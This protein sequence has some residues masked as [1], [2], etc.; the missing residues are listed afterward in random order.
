[1]ASLPCRG[2]KGTTFVLERVDIAR[3]P[4][5][6][7]AALSKNSLKSLKSVS[8]ITSPGTHSLMPVVDPNLSSTDK[9][10][11][12]RRSKCYSE[13]TGIKTSSSGTGCKKAVATLGGR[14]SNSQLQKNSKTPLLGCNSINFPFQIDASGNKFTEWF[15]SF[16]VFTSSILAPQ[17]KE[18]FKKLSERRRIRKAV[19]FPAQLGTAEDYEELADSIF[20]ATN[21][22]IQSIVPSLSRIDWPVSLHMI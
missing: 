17:Q 1:M 8:S 16:G 10:N 14:Y 22:A 3:D 9:N 7:F 21:G 12:N 18:G 4:V 11:L 13:V 15:N 19:I 5:A 20:R 2:N 6:A